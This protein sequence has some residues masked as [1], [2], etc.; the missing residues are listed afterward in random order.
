VQ[1]PLVAVRIETLDAVTAVGI[2]GVTPVPAEAAAGVAA[3]DADVLACAD[4]T[5]TQSPIF[6]VD[7]DAF[8]VVVIRVLDETVT[9][10][11]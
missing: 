10:T 7:A 1:E 2:A 6:S 11:C 3:G 5:V 8:F 4:R 9:A